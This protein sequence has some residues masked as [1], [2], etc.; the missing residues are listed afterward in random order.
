MV[1]TYVIAHC[2]KSCWYPFLRADL[3]RPE[4]EDLL[5]AI[6]IAHPSI[7]FGVLPKDTT[8][9]TA[10]VLAGMKMAEVVAMTQAAA[11]NGS[12][13]TPTRSLEYGDAQWLLHVQLDAQRC[14]KAIVDTR[15]K[16]KPKG[17]EPRAKQKN[18]R[19]VIPKHLTPKQIEAAQMVGECNGNI[20][21]AARKLKRDRKTVKQH[22]DMALVKMGR[23]AVKHVT[24]SLPAD[25]RGQAD[26]ADGGDRRRM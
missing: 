24:R 2:G 16:G 5:G 10:F 7:T 26:I 20:A 23:V 6:K 17:Q 22:Y 8:R 13:S 11:C 1:L 25:R 21:E 3:S 19:R 12:G 18:K 14:V 9:R 15:E 4:M